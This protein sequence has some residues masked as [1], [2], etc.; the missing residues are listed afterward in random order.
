VDLVFMD[1]ARQTPSRPGMGP[2]VAAGGVYVPGDNVRELE[3]AID[4]LCDR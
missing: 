2:L 4:A 1:D 3:A